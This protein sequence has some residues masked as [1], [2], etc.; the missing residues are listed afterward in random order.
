MPRDP[1]LLTDPTR[2]TRL[3]RRTE[4][5]FPFPV[6]NG[7]FIVATAAELAPGDLR[8]LHYFGRDLVLFRQ[9]DGTPRL[10]DAYCPHLGAHLAVGGRVDGDRIVCPFHGWAFDGESGRC[11]DVPY[12]ESD[13]IPR[14]AALRAYPTV[15][16]NHL[17]WA[18]HHLEGGPPFYE[19]P[20]VPE[21]HDP[22]WSPIVVRDFEIATCCQEMAE[23]NVDRAHFKYVHGTD[24]IPEEEFHVD[25]AYKRAVGNGGTFVREGFG[26]GLGVLRVQ[27]YT[28][29]VSSTTPID[30]DNV[31]VRWIF[32]SPQGLGPAA[33]E[34]AAEAFCG[35]ISQDIP[36]WE[37]KV[38]RDKP[39]LRPMEKDISEHR[40]WSLQF[41]SLDSLDE[42][43]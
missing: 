13:F 39:V 11:V 27:G 26:L 24:A 41:Y 19:V 17:I 23:N 3:T 22:G 20:E 8:P 31:H 25:G 18:W 40:R 36:I 1:A 5:R 21:F 12:D 32:T 10:V 37:N 43:A 9:A 29:F 16:R 34:E 38:Y 7:W 28:T 35:G 14:R 15:E 30:T 33:A 4:G 6:P 42:E 2:R